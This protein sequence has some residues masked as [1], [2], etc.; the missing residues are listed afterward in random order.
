MVRDR[1][2]PGNRVPPW[3][4]MTKDQDMKKPEVIWAPWR[5][6]FVQGTESADPGQASEPEYEFYPGADRDCFLCQAVAD[7]SSGS[8]RWRHIVANGERTIVVLN[9]YPYNNGH[10]L[11]APRR[12]VGDLTDLT[13]EERLDLMRETTRMTEELRRVVRPQGFNVGINLGSVAG[14]G[15]PGHLHIHIVPRWNGDTNF[16]PAVGGIRVIP[17]SLD[18]LW[19]ALTD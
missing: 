13:D 18:A 16:M 17:Q 8:A 14:A 19:S 3:A 9:K 12:H 11:V 7:R 5:L 15:L 4:G 1:V 10:L 2:H 6:D